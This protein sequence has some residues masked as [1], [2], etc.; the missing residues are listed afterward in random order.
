MGLPGRGLRKLPACH[1]AL[2]VLATRRSSRSLLGPAKSWHEVWR[3][4]DRAYQF[5]LSATQEWLYLS[6]C[7]L[8]A[9]HGPRTSDAVAA[10]VSTLEE[11]AIVTVSSKGGGQWV[12]VQA[13]DKFQANMWRVGVG[14]VCVESAPCGSRIDSTFHSRRNGMT[15]NKSPDLFN[16]LWKKL[17]PCMI[18]SYSIEKVS[19]SHVLWAILGWFSC[20]WVANWVGNNFSFISRFLCRWSHSHTTVRVLTIRDTRDTGPNQ[21]STASQYLYY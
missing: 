13:L 6:R 16:R 19:S 20:T 8:A 1:S 10:A 11:N 3:P 17:K 18:F 12:H 15:L 5:A 4:C 14:G 2:S 7:P 9:S 21:I